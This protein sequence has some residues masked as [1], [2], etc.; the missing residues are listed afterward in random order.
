MTVSVVKLADLDFAKSIAA[1]KTRFSE[2][3]IS[4]LLVKYLYTVDVVTFDL[5]LI[6]FFCLFGKALLKNISAEF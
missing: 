6:P 4:F 3:V 5:Q 2:L 1:V